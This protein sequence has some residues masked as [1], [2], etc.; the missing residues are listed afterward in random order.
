MGY[1]SDV[2]IAMKK[3]DYDVLAEQGKTNKDLDELLQCAV[4]RP[5]RR[6]NVG[7][8]A[9]TLSWTCIKWYDD[10]ESVKAVMD[11]I[12]ELDDMLFLRIGEDYMDTERL[13]SGLDYD[14]L[15]AFDVHREI[16]FYN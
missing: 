15:G 3:K 14:I 1:Y 11:F 12:K 2:A 4:L 6:N 13:E 16:D 8:N 5:L 9:V 7:E 10:F